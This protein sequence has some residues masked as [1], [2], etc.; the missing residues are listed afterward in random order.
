M[1]LAPVP[2]PPFAF[3]S[4]HG[5][6]GGCENFIS[7]IYSTTSSA[8]TACFAASFFPWSGNEVAG[9]RMFLQD[10][11]QKAASGKADRASWHGRKEIH[12]GKD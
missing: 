2:L 5:S 3:R 10:T 11:Q 1:E 8:M 7:T 6:R 12:D 4:A 9:M